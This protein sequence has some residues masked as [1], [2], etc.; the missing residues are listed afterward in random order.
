MPIICF[1][2]GLPCLVSLHQA[3]TEIYDKI[4]IK[5]FKTSSSLSTKQF[6]SRKRE[7]GGLC[8]YHPTHILI[9]KSW[10]NKKKTEVEGEE[11]MR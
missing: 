4:D 6:Q 2:R 10:S 3:M 9:Y 5:F 11:S 1:T 8:S 7:Q